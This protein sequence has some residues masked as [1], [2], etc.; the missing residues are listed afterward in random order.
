MGTAKALLGKG[1]PVYIHAHVCAKHLSQEHKISQTSQEPA[2][3]LHYGKKQ[4]K[5]TKNRTHCVV[6]TAPAY[7]SSENAE[8]KELTGKLAG[9]QRRKKKDKPSMAMAQSFLP[10]SSVG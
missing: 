8:L 6:F 7:F 2:I 5:Q 3:K 9:R 4:N 1:V 10:Q